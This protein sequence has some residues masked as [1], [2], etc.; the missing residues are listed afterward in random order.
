MLCTTLATTHF[1]QLQIDTVQW[2]ESTEVQVALFAER[3]RFT[4]ERVAKVFIEVVTARRRE[5][6][7]CEYAICIGNVECE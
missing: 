6:D 3:Q 4:F 5:A 7:E 2:Y 1:A